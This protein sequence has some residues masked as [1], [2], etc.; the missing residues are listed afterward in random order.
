MTTYTGGIV[1]PFDVADRQAALNFVESYARAAKIT[2]PYF[3]VH[4]RRFAETMAFVPSSGKSYARALELGSTALFQELLR[5]V[6]G[7]EEVHG[8]HYQAE[9]PE[10]S[11]FREFSVLSDRK[12]YRTHNVNFEEQALPFEDGYFDL[13]LCCEVIEHMERD[14]MYLMS[15]INRV[16]A[17]GGKLLLTTP[18][19]AS[20]RIVWAVLNGFRPH[21]FMQYSRDGSLYRH[22]YEYDVHAIRVLVESAGF[23][24]N[25]LTTIDTFERPVPEALELLSQK[26]FP[27]VDRGDNIYCRAHKVGPVSQRYPEPIYY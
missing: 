15:E 23:S 4:S 12:W 1:A 13:V 3:T 20:G 24:V 26:G 9:A 21:F 22:N 7:Y 6:F 2:D 27:T 8:T 10:K 16:L 17:P 5:T 18:N 14:P 25:D 11:Y 19:S